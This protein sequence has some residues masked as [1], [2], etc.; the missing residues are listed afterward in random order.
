MRKDNEKNDQALNRNS[1]IKW[2]LNFEDIVALRFEWKCMQMNLAAKIYSGS[3]AILTYWSASC[4]FL[5]RG[6]D[7]YCQLVKNRSF[8]S[9]MTSEVTTVPFSSSGEQLYAQ[10]IYNNAHD[11]WHGKVKISC[12]I[13]STRLYNLDSWLSPDQ[14]IIMDSR[15][16]WEQS[17][18]LQCGQQFSNQTAHFL[19]HL[20]FSFQTTK[21]KVS[22]QTCQVPK[23]HAL[24]LNPSIPKGTLHFVWIILHHIWI[25]TF[26]TLIHTLSAPP[27][28]SLL[29]DNNLK[30]NS[31]CLE[32]KSS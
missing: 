5:C 21:W 18:R 25:E 4:T 23:S 11:K 19:S 2:E 6:W 7:K 20:I 3:I 15:R 1:V 24:Q 22:L 30:Y 16:L 26:Q 32:H 29:T 8:L 12:H 13:P 28:A 14:G 9:I 31:H 17:E 10:P 27:C